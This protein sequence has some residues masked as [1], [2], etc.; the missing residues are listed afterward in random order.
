MPL[1]VM[2][3]V[4]EMKPTIPLDGFHVSSYQLQPPRSEWP[5][6]TYRHRWYSSSTASSNPHYYYFQQVEPPCRRIW[7]PTEVLQAPE[8][9]MF[10]LF[11]F[12]RETIAPADVSAMLCPQ[13]WTMSGLISLKLSANVELELS[14]G[15]AAFA[16]A[17]IAHQRSTAYDS[18]IEKL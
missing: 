14:Q 13:F 2:R 12:I 10:M 8:P 4:V 6:G 16:R 7:A 18:R 17:S 3:H 1:E 9:L 5:L 15:H 11:M